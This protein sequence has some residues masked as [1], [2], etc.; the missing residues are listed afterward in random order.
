MSISY[1]DDKD[2]FLE[3]K[4]GEVKTF[5][6]VEKL[7]GEWVLAK[8][9]FEKVLVDKISKEDGSISDESEAS[10]LF[11]DFAVVSR[12]ASK[13]GAIMKH[14]ISSPEILYEWTDKDTGLRADFLSKISDSTLKTRYQ[15]AKVVK[16]SPDKMKV[17]C[18]RL[19]KWLESE[20]G[21]VKC[22]AECIKASRTW[23]FTATLSL[24][25]LPTLRA[26]TGHGRSH[27][28]NLILAWI[29]G[30]QKTH[31]TYKMAWEKQLWPFEPIHSVEELELKMSVAG[32]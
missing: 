20:N 30:S 7:G 12:H 3:V 32:F 22:K 9:F 4:T 28:H 29:D 24:N 25:H 1:G 18:D 19:C 17:M 14:Q 16:K 26:S 31:H 23:T 10:W 21:D 2:F 8:E 15:L 5:N 6:I 27:W 13:N 11:K